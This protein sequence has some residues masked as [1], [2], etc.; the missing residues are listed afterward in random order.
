MTKF[1]IKEYFIKENSYFSTNML[2]S[3]FFW[4]VGREMAL[5]GRQGYCQSPCSWPIPESLT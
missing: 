5:H 2:F 3:V 1:D 4:R